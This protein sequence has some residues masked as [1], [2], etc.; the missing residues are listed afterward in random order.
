MHVQKCSTPESGPHI[1]FKRTPIPPCRRGFSPQ[2]R[3]PLNNQDRLFVPPIL[4]NMTRVSP[5]DPA[6][7]SCMTNKTWPRIESLKS[8]DLGREESQM[9]T[10]RTMSGVALRHSVGF[11]CRIKGHGAGFR[12]AGNPAPRTTSSKP[13]VQSELRG[14]GVRL[15]LGTVP[16]RQGERNEQ[17][18]HQSSPRRSLPCLIPRCH[19]LAWLFS[20][21]PRDAHPRRRW[22]TP[23]P[24]RVS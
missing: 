17:R 15:M 2:G 23:H 18:G 7:R 11:G 20:H 12:E 16:S 21:A 14:R 1:L 5:G 4:H 9:K 10:R 8:K 22:S 24:Q 6:V 3:L 19:G 13:G